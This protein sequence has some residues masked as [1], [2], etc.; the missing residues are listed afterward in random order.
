MQESA[1]G[2]SPSQQ[3]LLDPTD[4]LLLLLDHQS[5]LFQNVK[6]ITVA[7][8][9]AMSSKRRRRRTRTRIDNGDAVRRAT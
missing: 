5:G 2:K 8:L 1:A 9:R 4:P 6:D 7:E 3:D